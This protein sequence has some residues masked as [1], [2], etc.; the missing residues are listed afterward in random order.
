MRS[1][2]ILMPFLTLL[3]IQGWV[4]PAFCSEKEIA[5]D[6]ISFR[7]KSLAEKLEHWSRRWLGTP[8]RRD[9]LGE[10]QNSLI[11]RDPLTRFDAFDCTTW[12]ET[13]V[14][15]SLSQSFDEFQ[16]T[17]LR[18]R[19][20]DADPRFEARNHFIG[21]EWIPHQIEQGWMTTVIPPRE[22][23]L[24]VRTFV[25]RSNWFR[26]L[27]AKASN[28][29]TRKALEQ[30]STTAQSE[31]ET[32]VGFSISASHPHPAIPTP[33]VVTL[34]SP[35]WKTREQIG[36]DLSISHQGLLLQSPQ[37]LVFRHASRE[38]K[39]VTELPWKNYLRTMRR[40][41]HVRGFHFLH[42]HE[43]HRSSTEAR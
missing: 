16:K 40:I 14:S 29:R 10:G 4:A 36:T 41:K 31:F 38:T 35:H 21:L 43:P 20:H 12:V 25:D 33:A 26:T 27:A 42:I 19:Y 23:E 34:I 28:A 6:L 3:W 9:P 17:L 30:L 7:S 1:K 2:Q 8:Y 22:H 5:Q 11:D 15:L 24:Q 39:I 18:M 32:L 37:G 13:V